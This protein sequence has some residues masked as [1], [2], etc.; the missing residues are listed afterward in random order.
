MSLIDLF[1][2]NKGSYALQKEDTQKMFHKYF[3][4]EMA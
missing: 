4:K 3:K 1:F 2:S